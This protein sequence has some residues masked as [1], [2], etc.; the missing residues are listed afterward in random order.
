MPWKSGGE[1]AVGRCWVGQREGK[2]DVVVGGARWGSG[3]RDCMERR[4]E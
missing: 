1:H 3:F 4:V 2:E